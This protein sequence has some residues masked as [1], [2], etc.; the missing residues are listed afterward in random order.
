MPTPPT[1]TT[2]HTSRGTMNEWSST[3][4]PIFVDPVGSV[5]TRA[6]WLRLV[7]RTEA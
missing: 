3:Y 2:V 7:G 1:A 4:F 5:F 6:S